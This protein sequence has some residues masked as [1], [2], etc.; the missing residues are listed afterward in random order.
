MVEQ[1][2]D[3]D[4]E[5]IFRETY[6]REFGFDLH[7]RPILVDDLRVRAIAKSPALK[8]FPVACRGIL[9]QAETRTR[10]YF[11]EG[12][13][14]TPI[15]RLET[16]EAGEA[17]PGPAILIQDTSTILV[18]PGCRAE[19]TKY[20]DVSITVSPTPPGVNRDFRHSGTTG[21]AQSKGHLAVDAR[22]DP[23]QLSIFSNLFMSIAE[24]MGR[25][26]ERTSISVNIK[27]RLDFSCAI[28]DETGGLVANA[29]HV[30]VHL[31]AMSDAVRE[32]VETQQ[33][34]QQSF[35]TG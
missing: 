18:E 16:L 1:P 32:Q 28:F 35:D 25:I 13:L 9:P 10:C 30:P 7:D 15:Y 12:W 19:I 31:G 14:D 4:F 33:I 3:N 17:V 22:V 20:G 21:L 8:K 26:L 24:Q 27:E 11:K 29:P 23:V 2:H 34:H 5:R 6:L